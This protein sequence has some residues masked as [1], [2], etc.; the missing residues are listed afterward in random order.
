MT[1]QQHI[2]IRWTDIMVTV[3][4][5]EVSGSYSADKTDWMTVRMVGGGSKSARGGRAASSV[6]RLMLCELYAE[7]EQ[8][9]K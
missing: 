4:G 3:D 6:A 2:P 5:I 8:A 9:Q 1:K 7:A